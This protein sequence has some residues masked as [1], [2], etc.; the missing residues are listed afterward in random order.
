MQQ[1]NDSK[2]F[3][4]GDE[5]FL[6]PVVEWIK[7]QDSNVLKKILD[8]V[9]EVYGKSE[10]E[11][12]MEECLKELA[13]KNEQLSK[14]LLKIESELKLKVEGVENLKSK[15]DRLKSELSEKSS[16][17]L[18]EKTINEV[19][20]QKITELSNKSHLSELKEELENKDLEIMLLK[21]QNTQLQYSILQF[22]QSNEV[23]VKTIEDLTKKLQS[24][25]VSAYNDE[26]K[27]FEELS[28]LE[29]LDSFDED[30]KI[31]TPEQ[32]ENKEIHETFQ[33]FQCMALA[34]E[35]VLINQRPSYN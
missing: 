23:Y 1:W 5:G 15:L 34:L 4:T 21:T 31:V 28:S 35:E 14:S 18:E 10:Q 7:K 9:G 32:C 22:Q 27:S 3:K 24:V 30:Q 29:D 6:A 11:K 26:N 12:N 25:R 19:L 33:Y 2:N 17:L 8:V 13:E 16:Q 20:L